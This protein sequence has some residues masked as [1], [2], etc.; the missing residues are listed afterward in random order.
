MDL[1]NFL[2]DHLGSTSGFPDLHSPSPHAFLFG[3]MY[4]PLKWMGLCCG[5]WGT[6]ILTPI[7]K[8][9]KSQVATTCWIWRL[10]WLETQRWHAVL[11][12]SAAWPSWT[13]T[14]CF[15]KPKITYLPFSLTKAKFV[16][17]GNWPGTSA[18]DIRD[19]WVQKRCDGIR[20]PE[21]SH[22]SWSSLEC[23]EL[24]RSWLWVKLWQASPFSEENRFVGCLQ[25]L[26][27]LSF[28]VMSKANETNV[29]VSSVSLW[30]YIKV[31]DDVIQWISS[32]LSNCKNDI[33]AWDPKTARH[34]LYFCGCTGLVACS[35]WGCLWHCLK[36]WLVPCFRT[37]DAGK[38]LASQG[39]WG[40]EVFCTSFGS[41]G[42]VLWWCECSRKWLRKKRDAAS[43]CLTSTFPG[44][45]IPKIDRNMANCW[46]F[47]V[48]IPLIRQ[49][50]S[51][52][53]ISGFNWIA[54]A[55]MCQNDFWCPQVPGE[56]G[57]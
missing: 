21:R 47:G 6:L 51:L 18:R 37:R 36:A 27:F 45:M 11:V 39:N 35:F 13:P 50:S 28:H 1:E 49:H 48:P 16:W 2:E 42:G 55:S 46:M 4:R 22:W 57:E 41:P 7:P 25:N 24:R 15:Y 19:G 17:P 40:W 8:G 38:Q 30:S 9:R 5:A 32:A 56:R 14:H 23:L 31:P 12:P 3:A 29:F 20:S 53:V 33:K 10:Q 52:E 26:H 44:S 34:S 43:Q 54:C